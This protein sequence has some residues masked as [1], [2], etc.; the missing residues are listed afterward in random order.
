MRG[1]L[2]LPVI[3]KGEPENSSIILLLKSGGMPAQSDPLPPEQ[4]QLI[5]EW[6]KQGAQ[7]N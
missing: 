1:S 6:I 5:A 2:F 4:I 3:V 7:N